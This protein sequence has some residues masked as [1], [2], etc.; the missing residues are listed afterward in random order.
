MSSALAAFSDDRLTT[1]TAIV[2][3]PVTATIFVAS[4]SSAPVQ[5]CAEAVAASSNIG[6]M[7]TERTRRGED[8]VSMPAMREL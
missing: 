6:R 3:G 1:S 8:G 2:R 7:K 4:C 5:F